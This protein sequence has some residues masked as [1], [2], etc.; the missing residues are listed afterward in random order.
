MSVADTGEGISDGALD[1]I[2][3]PFFTTKA[4]GT[5][6]GL[7]LSQVFGFAKQSGG[8]VEV[9]SEPGAGATFILYLPHADAADRVEGTRLA[10]QLVD[11]H[12]ACVLVVEDNAP[13]GAFSTQ[14]LEELGYRTVLTG[15]A[16]AALAELAKD[17]QRFDVVFSD[18]VMPGM[19][20]VQLA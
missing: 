14:A 15:D 4:V 10:Q 20:G 18:V 9:R 16:D 12:G 6:T 11:G 3:E 7:G 1:R 8:E 13:V 2:F 19:N 17:A 5:G